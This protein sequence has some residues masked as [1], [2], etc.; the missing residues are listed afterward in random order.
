MDKCFMI[1]SALVL[2]KDALLQTLIGKSSSRKHNALSL[3][4]E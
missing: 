4:D 1:A 3:T 2:L